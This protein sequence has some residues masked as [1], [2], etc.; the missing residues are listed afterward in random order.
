VSDVETQI[1]NGWTLL[2]N[3]QDMPMIES[4]WCAPPTIEFRH[5]QDFFID[6]ITQYYL[7]EDSPRR[8]AIDAG[9][10]VGM[11]SLPFAKYYERV[12]SFEIN[13]EVRHCFRQNTKGV[14]NITRHDCGLSDA[15]TKVKVKIQTYS[16]GTHVN[17]TLGK[18]SLPVCRLDSF[19]FENV[20]LIKYDVERHELE[21]IHGSK[22]TILRCKPLLIIVEY[23]YLDRDE[24][25]QR[26]EFLRLMDSLGYMLFDVRHY[27][28]IFKLKTNKG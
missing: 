18:I 22:E 4:A 1:V 19:N 21:A 20:D 23:M 24:T 10:S 6:D 16:G 14:S 7:D 5:W 28:L 25:K 3:E 26:Q 17:P 27:D 2:A 8:I 11:S 15:D 9:S 12:H 13:P